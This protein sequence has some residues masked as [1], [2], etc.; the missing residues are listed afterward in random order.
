M[1]ILLYFCQKKLTLVICLTWVFHECL[2]LGWM[3]SHLVLES[4]AWEAHS[5]CHFVQLWCYLG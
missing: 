3:E 2:M 4:S 5:A 1:S